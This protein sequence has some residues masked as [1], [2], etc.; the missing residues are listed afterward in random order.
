M[1]RDDPC[2]WTIPVSGRSPDRDD[3][4]VGTIP[5]PGRSPTAA[6]DAP[7]A[8]ADARE[9][10]DAANARAIR[11]SELGRPIPL[12]LAREWNAAELEARRLSVTERIHTRH[13][14][15]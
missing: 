11:V 8:A 10:A 1:S 12:E 3:P 15:G 9:R 5:D 13:P 2:S 14:R 6:A 4:E 7:T